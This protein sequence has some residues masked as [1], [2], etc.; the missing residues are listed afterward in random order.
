MTNNCNTMDKFTWRLEHKD[1]IYRNIKTY[2]T[3]DKELLYGFINNNMGITYRGNKRYEPMDIKFETEQIQMANYLGLEEDGHFYTK[4]NFPPHKWGRIKPKNNLSLCVFVRGTRHKLAENNNIDIDM[5]NCHSNIYLAFCKH[6]NL[7]CVELQKYCDDPKILRHDIIKHHLPELLKKPDDKQLKDIAKNL[8]IRLANGGTYKQWMTDFEI[9]NREPLK[10]ILAL[11]QELKNIMDI[12]YKHNQ[13]ILTDVLANKKDLVHVHT[14]ENN[15]YKRTVMSLWSQTIERYL[16]EEAIKYVSEWVHIEEIL[17]CQDGFMIPKGWEWPIIIEDINNHVNSIYPY[18][19]KFMIKP[20]DE[21][22]NIPRHHY[23]Q[24]T[25]MRQTFSSYL[26]PRRTSHNKNWIY[27][28][29]SL[30]Q[31]IF[32]LLNLVQVRVNLHLLPHYI[33]NI[34]PDIL[35]PEY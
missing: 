3:V 7:P 6:H 2:E 15:K 33:K 1:T 35:H 13:H 5:V 9:T 20:F 17:P 22:I 34:K 28:I 16:Q 23:K 19:I 8:P 30:R 31:V 29:K 32:I 24:G 21:T 10:Q 14:D 18:N 25:A 4:Y 11:E 12:V 26:I 27:P